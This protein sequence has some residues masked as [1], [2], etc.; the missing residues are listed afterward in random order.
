M[1]KMVLWFGAVRGHVGRIWVHRRIGGYRLAE[2]G[3]V[4][5]RFRTSA[6]RLSVLSSNTTMAEFRG[7]QPIRKGCS[8]PARAGG[9]EKPDPGALLKSAPG[10][11]VRPGTLP[12]GRPA[13][14]CWW[15]TPQPGLGSCWPSTAL[16]MLTERKRE[17]ASI[18]DTG[19]HEMV[20][21]GDH[22]VHLD[23]PE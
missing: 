23:R 22:F 20:K 2:I 13:R 4:T 19:R 16:A 11:V 18:S 12:R 7:P 9:K 21:G 17:Y 15:V 8:S 6:L 14:R 5:S 10:T 1:A 3:S